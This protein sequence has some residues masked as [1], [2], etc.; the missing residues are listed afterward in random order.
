VIGLI[1]SRARLLAPFLAF[2][3]STLSRLYLSFPFMRLVPDMN[4]RVP[5]GC[6]GQTRVSFGMPSLHADS[7]IVETE[8]QWPACDNRCLSWRC[9]TMEIGHDSIS[10]ATSCRKCACR[11]FVCG[12]IDELNRQILIRESSLP[13][14]KTDVCFP[15]PL[16]FSFLQFS[17]SLCEFPGISYYSNS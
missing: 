15:L 14:I 7:M 13:S 8:L 3:W 2:R 4:T 11:P 9:V 5:A 1:D 17:A 10:T 6:G 12:G 16:I